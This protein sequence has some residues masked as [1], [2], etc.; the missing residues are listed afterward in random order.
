ML[1]FNDLDLARYEIKFIANQSQFFR[2]KNWLLL[3]SENFSSH[4]SSRIINNIY[5]DNIDCDSYWENLTGISSRNKIRLRWYG[6][7]EK[8]YTAALE[9]KSKKNK[10]GFKYSNN[11]FFKKALQEMTFKEIRNVIQSQLT[12]DA[13]LRF[14]Q[15]NVAVLGNQYER[16]Y[17]IDASHT[18]RATIDKNLLF[19]DQRD[20]KKPNFKFKS[21]V[22]EV[23]I[24]EIKTP[25]KEINVAQK[26]LE[27][28]EFTPS[29][30]SK[31][32][33]GV[34]SLLGFQ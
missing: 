14:N 9:I 25:A 10:L 7:D 2:F 30:S 5:F 13:L 22:P 8:T 31:Y 20:K 15:S 23:S 28:I 34:Q 29:K 17:F 16:D 6:K 27:R 11:I 18:I 24:L 3:N 1:N 21:L 32:V 26:M 4:Y 33:I 12:G 19:F